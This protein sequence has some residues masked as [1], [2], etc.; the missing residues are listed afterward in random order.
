MIHDRRFRD[1]AASGHP[2]RPERLDA[3]ERALEHAA[4]RSTIRRVTPVPATDADLLLVH[5]R[6]HV[7]S[8]RRLAESGGWFDPDTYCEKR[9]Y[10]T[11]LLAAGAACQAAEVAREG[12]PVFA[13][14]RPPGH[15]ATSE[16]AMGFCL[17]NNVAIAA[18]RARARRPEETVAILDI[19]VHHGNGTEEILKAHQD[20][21]YVSLH[22]SPLYPGTG[23]RA[24]SDPRIVDIPL[25]PGTG[26]RQW[27]RALEELA[28]PALLAFR[29]SLLLVSAGFDGD[30][31]DPLAAFTLGPDDFRAAA[32]VTLE[33]SRLAGTAPAWILEGGYDEPALEEDIA[34]VLDELGSAP[35]A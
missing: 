30:A 25:P 16:R 3:V 23:A 21:L 9:S 5:T 35:S 11:A 12:T 26:S 10:G 32:R 31:R 19:D 15:H 17:F 18:V 33:I 28:A 34:S 7:D 22:Q 2:E 20:I 8:V 4:R 13:A 6:E 27:R 24:S 14:V 1:H 29:P